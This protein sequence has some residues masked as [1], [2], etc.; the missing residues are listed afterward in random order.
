MRWGRV[1]WSGKAREWKDE[2]D[3]RGP[4]DVESARD[5]WT[6]LECLCEGDR[7]QVKVNGTLVNEVSEV[8]PSRGKIL[9]QCEGSEVFFRKLELRSL[10]RH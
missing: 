7:I 1:N 6:R 8:F 10:P 4:R 9:L 3:F 2:L 5:D